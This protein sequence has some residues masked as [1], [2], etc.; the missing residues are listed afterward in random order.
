MST[1]ETSDVVGE[2]CRCSEQLELGRDER[3]R[4]VYSIRPVL[5]TGTAGY[6][7]HE[8]LRSII[9]HKMRPKSR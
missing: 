7:D 1:L 2:R 5:S 3:L 4:T 9:V 6:S 8:M